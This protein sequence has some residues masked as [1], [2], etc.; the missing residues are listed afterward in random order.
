MK[1]K[2]ITDLNVEIINYEWRIN[3]VIQQNN[4]DTLIINTSNLL[5]GDNNVSLKIKNLCGNWSNKITNSNITD[6]SYNNNVN[7]N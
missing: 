1:L 2:A 7:L 6:M 5:L 4:T 3:N